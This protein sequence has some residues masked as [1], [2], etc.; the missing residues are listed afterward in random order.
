MDGPLEWFGAMGAIVAAGL[1]AA[2]LGR[3]FTGWAF[4]LFLAVSLAWIASGLR[5]DA[6]SLVAQNAL[7]LAVNGWGVWQYL[8]SPR[9]KRE[10]DRQ[11]HIAEQARDE[12]DRADPA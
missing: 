10:I 4:V 3:R 9:K 7:L 12:L 6:W 1:I 5:H 2:D 11:E 8:L